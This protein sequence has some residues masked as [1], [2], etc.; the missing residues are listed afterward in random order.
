MRSYRRLLERQLRA[1]EEQ[2]GILPQ[3][4]TQQ[5]ASQAQAQARG[6]QADVVSLL[7][8]ISELESLLSRQQGLGQGQ[9]QAQGTGV[10]PTGSQQPRHGTAIALG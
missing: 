2:A 4:Q 9:G 3:T 7:A 8:R 5:A 1:S 10:A 6:G